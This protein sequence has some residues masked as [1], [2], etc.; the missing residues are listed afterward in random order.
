MFNK[1]RL[2]VS[3]LLLGKIK[4]ISNQI[5]LYQHIIFMHKLN[6]QET[7]RIF[8][9]LIKKPV[10]KY[11]TN[12]SK[13]NFCLKNVSLNSIKYSIFFCGPKSRNEILHK[14]QKR[15]RILFIFSKYNKIKIMYDKK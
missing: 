4:A 2:S 3:R 11:Q 9:D 15:I 6:N 13:S 7:Q 1:D 14:E 8:N 12:Y 5:N 10:H